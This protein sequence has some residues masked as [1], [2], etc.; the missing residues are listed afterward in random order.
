MKVILND[1][2]DKVEKGAVS[3]REY[4]NVCVAEWDFWVH[5]LKRT[6]KHIKHTIST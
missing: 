5:M 3:A 1:E 4:A 2:R 6:H